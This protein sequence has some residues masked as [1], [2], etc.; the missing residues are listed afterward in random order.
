MSS[1]VIT[2]CG[3]ALGAPKGPIIDTRLNP[4]FGPVT[5]SEEKFLQRAVGRQMFVHSALLE[6]INTSYNRNVSHFCF[7]LQVFY[8]HA[9]FALLEGVALS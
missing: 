8:R 9:F 5:T 3:R 2:C 7:C 1:M 4:D 6:F